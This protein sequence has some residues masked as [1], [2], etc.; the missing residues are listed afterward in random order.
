MQKKVHIITNIKVCY[1]HVKVQNFRLE[2]PSSIFWARQWKTRKNWKTR[3]FQKSG[4]SLLQ[5]SL[6]FFT[7]HRICWRTLIEKKLMHRITRCLVREC[8]RSLSWID[9]FTIFIQSESSQKKSS[10]EIP[11]WTRVRV[12]YRD[13]DSQFFCEDAIA[14][15]VSHHVFGITV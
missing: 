2:D 14:C 15:L 3:F 8:E 13:L 1:D 9:S 11:P 4:S 5:I 12:V 7:D 10:T 6:P